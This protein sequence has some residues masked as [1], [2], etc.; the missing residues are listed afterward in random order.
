MG[1]IVGI[2]TS[3]IAG[4]YYL[5]R[6]TCLSQLETGTPIIEDC[7]IEGVFEIVTNYI[8]GNCGHSIV[9]GGCPLV[10]SVDQTPK[11]C[12]C[13]KLLGGIGADNEQK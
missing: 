6:W 12:R 7:S 13:R 8:G 10:A 3:V 1:Q 4:I 11:W 9:I 5:L 2:I